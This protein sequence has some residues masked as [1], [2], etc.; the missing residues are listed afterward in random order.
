MKC[1]DIGFIQ[2]YLDGELN[3]DERKQYIQHLDQCKSCQQKLE[4]MSKLNQWGQVVLDDEFTNVG[5]EIDIDVERAWNTFEQNIQ[6]HKTEETISKEIKKKGRWENM[7]KSSKRWITAAAAAAV[8]CVSLTVPEVR[9]GASS[10]LSIFRVKDV[11]FVQLTDSDLREIEGWIS[12]TEEGEKS[13]KGIGKIGIKD[14]GSKKDA[15]FQSEQ[16]AREAGYAV[17]KVPNGYRVTNVDVNPSFIMQF[18]LDTEKANKLLK[19]LQSNTQFE[20][21]LNGK[22]FS[23]TVP[24]SVR[25][26]IEIEGDRAS[27]GFSYNVIDTPKISVPEGVDVAKLQKTVLELPIIPGNVKTQLAGIQDW[28]HTLPIPYV[29]KDAKVSET[30]VQGVKAVLYNT[31]YENVLIWEKDGKMHMI[32]QHK[33]QGKDMNASNIM[34]LANELK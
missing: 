34:K 10:L 14:N 8:V 2:A 13:I 18:E 22:Q 6:N 16:Q 11:Q 5:Q 3:R 27:S 12:K 1:Q 32:E 24:E 21:A 17:P 4:E 31:E 7:K 19:Q 15:H 20:S 28:T 26:Q 9:A 25:T 29:A 30:S 33:E 23:V